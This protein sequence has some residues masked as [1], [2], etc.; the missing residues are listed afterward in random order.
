MKRLQPRSTRTD[1]LFPYTTLFRSLDWG[2]GKVRVGFRE[3]AVAHARAANP[4]DDSGNRDGHAFT[5][6]QS[7]IPDPGHTEDPTL[8]APVAGRVFRNASAAAI[9]AAARGRAGR[10]GCAARAWRRARP[11][12]VRRSPASRWPGAGGRQI[13]RAHV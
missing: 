9:R 10:R 13:G 1:T 3:Y 7:R 4:G 2:F 5:N 11:T 8:R 6:P 12:S